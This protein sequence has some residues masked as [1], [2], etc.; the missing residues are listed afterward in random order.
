M[1]LDLL[2]WDLYEKSLPENF[3]IEK[4][5]VARVAVENRGGYLLYSESGELEGIIQGKF[6]RNAKD[7][8]VYP[9]VGDWVA[10]EKLQGEEKAIIKEILPRKSKISRKRA[11]EDIAEQIIA[12]NIDIAFIVQGLDGDFNVS[13]LERYIAMAIEGGCEPIVVLN[14]SDLLE[15][16]QNKIDEVAEILSGIR[17]FLISAKNK[18]GIEEIEK[19]IIKGMSVVFVGSSGAGKSTLVNA[20]LGSDRQKTELI[21][22]DDSKGRHTTTK[23]ELLV[24][25]SG[26]LMIDTPG[27]RELGLWTTEKSL[28]ETFDDIDVFAQNCKFNDCDHEFS[29]GC[30]VIEALKNGLISKE[31]YLNYLKLKKDLDPAK[32]KREANSAQASKRGQRRVIKRAEHKK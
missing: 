2:G 25:P 21:R 16:A 15:N 8:T 23:R 31:R 14:K 18:N 3:K 20:L 28:N 30:A 5:N 24:L 12:T 11:G 32:A 17:M 7:E 4:Q 29:Q 13:R 6:R 27:M 22:I 19:I 10:I 9:K 26:G 1:N